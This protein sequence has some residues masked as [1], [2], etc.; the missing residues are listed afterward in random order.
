M[1]LLVKGWL[2]KQT[3]GKMA[4]GKSTIRWTDIV[5]KMILGEPS[6]AKC[7]LY[8][9]SLNKLAWYQMIQYNIS[10]EA[11]ATLRN[12]FSVKYLLRD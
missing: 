5:G 3:L 11:R 9:R 2:G 1:P 8:E 6:L 4:V 12:W 10:K 7:P